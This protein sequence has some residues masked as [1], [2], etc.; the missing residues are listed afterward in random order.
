MPKVGP[1]LSR[2]AAIAGAVLVL[3]VTRVPMVRGETPP[4]TTS[5]PAAQAAALDS[6][7]RALARYEALL[8]KDNDPAHQAAARRTLEGFRQR[9][10][11]LQAAFDASRCDDLRAE[12]NLEYHRLAA[13]ISSPAG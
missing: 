10:D 2:I 1:G 5:V 3:T 9:R 8:P 13:W 7:N 11:A 4:A 12:L 6:L